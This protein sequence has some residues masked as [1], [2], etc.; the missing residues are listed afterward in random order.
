MKP[1]ICWW[2]IIVAICVLFW[3]FVHA[4]TR[5]AVV[6][7]DEV[8]DIIEKLALCESSGNPHAIHKNDGKDGTDSVGILQF[9]LQ[10][11]K[12]QALAFKLFPYA[13]AA[14]LENIWRD[15]DAQKK[16]ADAMIRK[17]KANLRHWY[18]CSKKLGLTAGTL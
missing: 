7:H 10:T 5:E 2:L 9:K 6:V 16:V 12:E 4:P 1:R 17:N 18:I 13:E 15:A 8:T 14:E 3:G 11:F